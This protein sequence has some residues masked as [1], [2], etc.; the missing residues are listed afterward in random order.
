MERSALACSIQTST[1]LLFLVFVTWQQSDLTS[2]RP[3]LLLDSRT[4]TYSRAVL[5]D[6][7][8]CH[9]GFVTAL[10]VD[11]LYFI[12][13]IT[14]SGAMI[15]K[16]ASPHRS[17]RWR[18]SRHPFFRASSRN[19]RW[20]RPVLLLAA[21]VAF[22]HSVERFHTCRGALRSKYTPTIYPRLSLQEQAALADHRWQCVDCHALDQGSSSELDTRR[23]L[24]AQKHRWDTLGAGW[25]GTTFKYNDSAIKVFEQQRAPFRNCVPGS[26][27]QLRWPTE[28]SAS[29][30]LGGLAEN[31]TTLSNNGF[32]T[33][34]DY[35][36][37]P[38]VEDQP[39]QWYFVTPF[40]TNGNVDGLRRKL[41]AD[42]QDYTARDLDIIF[43]PSLEGILR[44]L[45]RM[46]ADY[47]LCHDDI[48]LDNL[49]LGP[50]N[51]GS[52]GPLQPNET[53]NWLLGDL[54]NVRERHHPYHSSTL[55]LRRKSNLADCR[56]NDV[57]RLIKIYMNF[58][59]QS[60]ADMGRFD[61]EFFEESQPW[62]RL[63]WS[64]TDQIRSGEFPTAVATLEEFTMKYAP[65]GPSVDTIGR[66][67]AG[68]T[69]LM[70]G[71][72]WGRWWILSQATKN[73]VGVSASEKIAR[74]WGLV[75]LFGTPS[76]SCAA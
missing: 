49:F 75:W 58:L 20:L 24:L 46:H 45:G 53:T 4:K 3:P 64:T 29:L 42:A 34:T 54:G 66:Q 5:P 76:Q 63:F 60:V 40:M 69:N 15:D 19:S 73:A 71:L 72:I 6:S 10:F 2:H 41:R 56:A 39:S 13:L 28:I 35:F 8:P 1:T 44:T 21:A 48:K 68:L 65:D 50:D 51:S 70:T 43:R 9:D 23:E 22:I 33:V 57:Y 32:L 12:I 36:L 52:L 55:W 59:R 47:D 67:P 38:S 18:R 11:Q 17:S 25:E 31:A 37:A 61:H 30:I 62:S 14:T 7:S 16:A 26:K 74:F 27:P